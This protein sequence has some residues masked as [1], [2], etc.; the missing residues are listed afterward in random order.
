MFAAVCQLRDQGHGACD[1]IH[2]KP[3]G[4]SEAYESKK[5]SNSRAFK[6]IMERQ[7]HSGIHT[8]FFRTFITIGLM[9]DDA[10][11]TH[12]QNGLSIKADGTHNQKTLI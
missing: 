7:T 1:C 4:C 2:H 9:T 12:K 3:L 6:I 11:G 10:D 8:E 5:K